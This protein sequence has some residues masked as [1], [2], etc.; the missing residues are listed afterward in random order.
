[1][2]EMF[3][4]DS[5]AAT[6]HARS[7]IHARIYHRTQLYSH[8]TTCDYRLQTAHGSHIWVRL[9][10]DEHGTVDD[11]MREKDVSFAS[12]VHANKSHRSR[13]LTR[14]HSHSHSHRLCNDEPIRTI[15]DRSARAAPR[16]SCS[17]ARALPPPRLRCVDACT[18][19]TN[20]AGLLRPRRCTCHHCS[21][22]GRHRRCRATSCVTE[23]PSS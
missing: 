14:S 18:L 1:M 13:A 15:D 9:C 19:A 4:N 23:P 10:D 22:S 8:A 20:A 5:C 17:G 6:I 21:C 3:R 12:Q 11:R 2:C 16:D 7:C